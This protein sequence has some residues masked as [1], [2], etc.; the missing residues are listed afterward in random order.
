MNIGSVKKRRKL[1]IV[2]VGTD[3]GSYNFPPSLK[4]RKNS[5]SNVKKSKAP[6]KKLRLRV[7]HVGFEE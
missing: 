3:D 6:L 7:V 1:K 4:K 2:H 5:I